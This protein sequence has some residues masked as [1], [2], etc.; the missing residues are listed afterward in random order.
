MDAPNLQQILDDPTTGMAWFDSLG[1]SSSD[2]AHA[3]LRR[4]AA[5]GIPIDLL[6]VVCRQMAGELPKLSDPDMALRNLERFVAA[7][8]NPLSLGTLFERDPAALPTL[9]QIFSTSQ[10][11][12]DLLARDPEGY[13]LLRMTEGAPV[14]R[15]EL[16]RELLAEVEP[17]S[18]ERDVMATLRRIKHRE[19]M[20]IAY[21]DIVRSQALETVTRQISY[22]ADALV[23]AAI[24]FAGKKVGE[25]RGTPLRPDGKP[26][27]FVVLALGK[28][29]GCELNY[30]SDI[31]LIALY[32]EDG[33]T[34]GPRS[35]S[36][37]EFYD[38]MTRKVVKLL[39]EATD[40]GSVYR[41]DMRLR[42][43][44]SQ[45][46]L[47][48]S[49]RAMLQYYD[50]SGRT[51]ERQAYVK[52]RPIAGNLELGDELLGH[53][54][55]WIYRRYLTLADITGI[56]SLKRRIERGANA[57]GFDQRDVKTGHGGIRDIEFVIQ[58]LQLVNGGTLPEVRTGNTLQAIALLEK[59]KCLT[60]Q[61]RGI[62]DENYR[63]LRKL[64]HRL[65]IMFD[66]QTH[67]LPTNRDEMRKLA[68][69]L[70]Y[71]ATPHCSALDAFEADLAS[72]TED[73]RKILNF[74]LHDAFGDDAKTEPEVDLV[75][76]PE[77]TPERI[78]AVLG[79]Y[80]F[81]DVDAAYTNLMA[82]ATD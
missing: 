41:V 48:N 21:G 23:E 20:R 62:L 66:L 30:S 42:P 55:P 65:Q 72:K 33:K 35:V 24:R 68:I 16:V 76:D 12:S 31:D 80:A 32:D 8:R 37:A 81:A 53:L 25:K 70:G 47:I 36:N 67:S 49:M 50:V 19:T 60:P 82:L 75:N 4:I 56:K 40:Q 3:D 51:W 11:L 58:F 5:Q 15:D 52:A 29:G 73:N 26:A 74:L 38:Q 61:E 64:E 27:R 10:Y 22:L 17:L 39:G 14:A 57:K 46:P 7:S 2:A 59:N 43:H 78:E 9:L 69:R 63:L 1:L 44:G 6:Q 79:K 77:P 18:D 45:G 71:Q 34:D 13:D 28:L 54:Q